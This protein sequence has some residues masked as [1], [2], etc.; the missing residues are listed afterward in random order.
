MLIHS[1]AFFL[2]FSARC[3][4][5]S[6]YNTAKA[7]CTS[8]SPSKSCVFLCLI[9][10]LSLQN[11]GESCQNC[12]PLN[13]FTISHF[14]SAGGA[15]GL[16]RIPPHTLFFL[17]LTFEVLVLPMDCLTSSL[18]RISLSL[19]LVVPVGPVDCLPSP[20]FL[21]NSLTVEV[22]VVPV[23]CLSSPLSRSLQ[24]FNCGSAGG[25]CGLSL[26]PS[27]SLQLF[28]CGSAGG[29]CGLFLLPSLS[30][31]LALD[32]PVVP[33]DCFP[34]LPFPLQLS[35]SVDVLVV[36]VDCFSSP[37]SPTL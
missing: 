8:T 19:T 2:L 28:N 36:P 34:S 37:L 14:G 12:L 26:L 25:A 1:L 16:S 21:S 24:R 5:Q 6:P 35:S 15:S 20:L 11:M 22:P 33:V 13:P 31:S 30:S 7:I 27:L 23:V 18:S 10:S 32:V 17:S 3:V 29:A 4:C 9:F